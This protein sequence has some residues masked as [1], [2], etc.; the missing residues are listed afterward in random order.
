MKP[1][2]HISTL[3]LAA[4]M[5]GTAAP[6]TFAAQAAPCAQYGIVQAIG[7]SPEEITLQVMVLGAPGQRKTIVLPTSSATDY[8]LGQRI[9][10]DPQPIK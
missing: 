10:V 4:L 3:V 6:V 8:K 1:H 5:L 7:H 9:C 2:M